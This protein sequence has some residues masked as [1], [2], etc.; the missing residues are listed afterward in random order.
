VNSLFGDVMTW[1]M[2]PEPPIPNAGPWSL[3]EKLNKE[4]DVTG[5]FIL[6]GHPFNDYRI[7]I[8]RL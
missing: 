7:E 1:I 6:F 2:L 3:L 8:E 5:I 4:K